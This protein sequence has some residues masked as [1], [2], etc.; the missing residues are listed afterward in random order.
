MSR[1]WLCDLYE[2]IQTNAID[3]PNFLKKKTLL[4]LTK[5]TKICESEF[6]CFGLLNLAIL[7]VCE[8]DVNVAVNAVE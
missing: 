3:W 6:E 7:S 4:Y 8:R 1:R 2:I 5:N